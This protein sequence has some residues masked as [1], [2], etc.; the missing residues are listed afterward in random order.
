M[1][2]P[3]ARMNHRVRVKIAVLENTLL[4]AI[5]DELVLPKRIGY[6]SGIHLTLQRKVLTL[7]L[8]QLLLLSTVFFY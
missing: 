8:E 5:G 6:V 4:K 7:G 3:S 2:I 1:T